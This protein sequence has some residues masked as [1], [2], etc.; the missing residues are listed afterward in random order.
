MYCL[1]KTAAFAP[2]RS[3]LDNTTS[4][5][6]ELPG[7]KAQQGE[8]R[9]CGVA[10]RPARVRPNCCNAPRRRAGRDRRQLS[11]GRSRPRG[12]VR[13]R[14]SWLPSIAVDTSHDRRSR[15]P[16]VLL[17]LHSAPIYFPPQG[18]RPLPQVPR[19]D[20]LARRHWPGSKK[21]SQQALAVIERND[22]L[23]L[24]A[25]HPCPQNFHGA[26]VRMLIY[27][28]RTA[29]D[30]K[31]RR[32][33]LPARSRASR[34]PYLLLRK[35]RCDAG[36]THEYHFGRFLHRV[37]PGGQRRH[38]LPRLCVGL[39]LPRSAKPVPAFLRM[40]G[41]MARHFPGECLNCRL[42]QFRHSPSTMPH[43]TEIDD[44]FSVT[45][46]AGGSLAHVGIHIAAPGPG[47]HARLGSRA[48]LRATGYR[49]STCRGARSPCCPMPIV[50]QFTLGRGAYRA[51]ALAVSRGRESDLRITAHDTCHR[52]GAG[53]CQSAPP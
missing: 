34:R 25:G 13:F 38:A 20:I 1:K 48:A 14:S 2:A 9:Q 44:A 37:F 31:P 45:A 5:Q 10:L 50:E 36:D 22:R 41:R 27:K 42:R 16:S 24:L 49:P 18:Q 11:C 35:M 7:G 40:G 21:R 30:R 51:G 29:T 8:S 6:V 28:P 23:Q 43:T 32:W 33:K 3:W 26:V 12:R 39:I 19:P 15:R 46:H 17:R 47:L 52:T 53:C 4:V